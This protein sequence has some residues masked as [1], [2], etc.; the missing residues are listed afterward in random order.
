MFSDRKSKHPNWAL[1]RSTQYKISL[2]VFAVVAALVFLSL[3]SG[4]SYDFWTDAYSGLTT[5][6]GISATGGGF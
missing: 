1:D 3:A 4:H 2:G 5:V 6:P